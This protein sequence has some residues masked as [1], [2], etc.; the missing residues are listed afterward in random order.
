M[1]PEYL[2]SRIDVL[3]EVMDVLL[4]TSTGLLIDDKSVYLRLIAEVRT[5]VKDCRTIAKLL[6]EK[7]TENEQG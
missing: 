1:S 5:T 4:E 3:E 6:N 7:S 2:E